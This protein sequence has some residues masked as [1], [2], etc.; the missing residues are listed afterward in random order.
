[1]IGGLIDDQDTTSQAGIPGLSRWQRLGFLFRNRI[2]TSHKSELI[3]LLTPRILQRGGLPEPVPGVAPMGPMKIPNTGPMPGPA[4]RPVLDSGAAPRDPGDW[5]PEIAFEKEAIVSEPSGA[6]SGERSAEAEAAPSMAGGVSRTAAAS[7]A[8]SSGDQSVRPSHH[9]I[10]A[11]DDLAAIAER[12]YGSARYR[13]PLWLANQSRIPDPDRLPAGTA[14]LLPPADELDRL[15]P[16]SVPSSGVSPTSGSYHPGDLTKM[17]FRRI[18]GDTTRQDEATASPR[19]ADYKPGDLTRSLARRIRGDGGRAANQPAATARADRQFELARSAGTPDRS[20]DGR[21]L[22]ARFAEQRPSLLSG[23]TSETRQ[24]EEPERSTTGV[25]HVVRTGEDF[26][27]IAYD[28]YQSTALGE[29]LWVSNRTRVSGPSFLRP[30]MKI[31]IPRLSE[32]RRKSAPHSSGRSESP[33]P[34]ETA[35]SGR[36]GD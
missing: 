33:A 25:E 36:S 17:V 22:A 27:S 9:V 12:Y 26:Q 6:G 14:I 30:G 31:V 11:G 34:P 23:E 8:A 16:L 15:E 20:R 18:G 19:K 10:A 3:V 35:D 2:S 21:L 1:V 29:A 28:Y 32:L 24:S 7:D 13:Y 5:G 4:Y